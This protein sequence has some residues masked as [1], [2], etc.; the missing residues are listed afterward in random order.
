MSYTVL[1]RRY[2]SSTFDEVV[3]QDHVAN[4]LKR[5]IET[6]RIAHAFLFCGTRGT[7]KT[8]MARILAKALNCQ[9][10][11]GPTT[12]P[13]GECDS[14]RGIARGEDIDYVEIDAASHTGVDATRDVIIDNVAYRPARGRFKIFLI[15]E[16]HMF[17][18]SSFNA[19]LKTLEEPPAH[20]KFILATTEPEKLPITI[21]SRC[22]RYDFRSISPQQVAEH[23][24]AICKAEKVAADDDAMLRVAKAGAGS[25]RDSLSL[26]DRLLSAGEKRVTLALIEQLL[27]LP[28]S[29]QVMAMVQAMGE[30]RPQDAL[31]IADTLLSGGLSADTLAG[32]LIDH[33]HGLLL[34]RVCGPES[35]VVKQ[36]GYVGSGMAAQ[37]AQFDP[38]TLTQDL[39]L[40]EELRR[41]MRSSPDPR[42]LFD[43][44]L[45]RL[46][47][48][49]QFVQLSQLLRGMS[50]K[51]Q[52]KLV[53]IAPAV[54][55][56]ALPEKKK[57]ELTAPVRAEVPIAP[58]A[59]IVASV[60][61]PMPAATPAA[62]N[63][64]GDDDDDSL[65]QPGRVWDDAPGGLSLV[66][67]VRQQTLVAE[68]AAAVAPGL[69]SVI[70][71]QAVDVASLWASFLALL[72]DKS[73]RF[74]GQ[75]HSMS[76]AGFED[77]VLTIRVPAGMRV[78][79]ERLERISADRATLSGY[80]SQAA[81]RPIG[82][83]FAIDTAAPVVEIAVPSSAP[84]RPT[85]PSLKEAAA[86]AEKGNI[87]LIET[88]STRPTDEQM[89][90]A[91]ADPLVKS[92]MEILGGQIKK[93]ELQH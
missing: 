31:G 51:P 73:P 8:S 57:P 37:A 92:V 18:K 11:E 89:R 70:E 2:R 38:A 22:Q 81:G 72:Q 28:H 86:L 32:T 14:C 48:S 15:D 59:P 25:M 93:I 17:S 54:A 90:Q 30:G 87:R 69:T 10:S 52:T 56:A 85:P 49:E 67:M 80:L 33:L 47:L 5:A 84:V 61:V 44:T 24:A 74:F 91:M 3:G 66:E 35:A 50:G 27:G 36:A 68:Q 78:G 40:L 55:A 9:K 64:V 6:S 79:V 43:A 77:S 20:V 34:M 75:V 21:L 62:P 88:A 45:V 26:L 39:Q 12:K 46:A 65:P 4:T 19:L 60:V 29:E 13:C 42:A 53:A 23:L 7:G 16:V 71:D 41:S 76:P 63:A 82:L 83:K 1:A 58:V